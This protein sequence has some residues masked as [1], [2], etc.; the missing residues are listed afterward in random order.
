MTAVLE[1]RDV[2]AGYGKARVLDGVDLTV[3]ATERVILLGANGSGKSTMAKTLMGLTTIYGGTID[4]DGRSITTA[5]AWRRARLGLGYV[6]QVSNVFRGLTVA[7]NLLIGGQ[8]VPHH[9]LAERLDMLYG[10]FP[11]L[12]Q[13]RSTLA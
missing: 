12:H 1:V 7:E 6:P 11:T 2:R 3:G 8:R 10:L 9:T 5:P 13:R 4:W